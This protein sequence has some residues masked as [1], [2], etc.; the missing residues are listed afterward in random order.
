MAVSEAKMGMS[1]PTTDVFE[2][3]KYQVVEPP[4]SVQK[5]D[6]SSPPVELC[7]MAP[8][9]EGKYPLLLFCHGFMLTNTWYTTLLQF[10]ASHGYIVIAPNVLFQH[11]ISYFYSYYV[12]LMF[13]YF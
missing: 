1:D 8:L 10:I 5:S 13:H 11:L 2:P 3:G 9:Q 6:R 7:I 12:R 4:I